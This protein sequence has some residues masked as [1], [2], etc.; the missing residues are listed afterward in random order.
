MLVACGS[1]LQ[2]PGTTGRCSGGQGCGKDIFPH[3]TWLINVTGSF[4]LGPPVGPGVRHAL[5]EQAAVM[6]RVG[7]R[8]ARYDVSTFSHDLVHLCEK[9]QV[10]I[11]LLYGASTIAVGLAAA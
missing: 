5:P 2:S 9:G 11:S 8:G 6:A 10:C 1:P 4:A 3:G 7:F